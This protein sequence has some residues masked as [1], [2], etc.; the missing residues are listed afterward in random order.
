[1]GA[2]TLWQNSV[3]GHRPVRHPLN[4]SPSLR[5]HPDVLH[6]CGGI[7]DKKVDKEFTVKEGEIHTCAKGKTDM[8]TNISPVA[9]IHRI[10]I[11]MPA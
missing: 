6:R 8:A 3:N 5:R 11:L 9:G 1:M 2:Q 7:Q 4:D 10:G